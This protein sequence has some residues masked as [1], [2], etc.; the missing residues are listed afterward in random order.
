MTIWLLALFL[1]GGLGTVGGQQGAVR[2]SVKL[3]GVL[4]AVLMARPLGPTMKPLVA[5]A[6]IKSPVWSWLLPPV[7]A[8]A[9]VLIVFLIIAYFVSSKVEFYFR[10]SVPDEQRVEFFRL[11]KRLGQCLGLATGVVYLV[12]I[13][14]IVL[15]FGY[16]T[17]QVASG[18]GDSF[19]MQLLNTAH[20]D[21]RSTGLSKIAA[22]FNPA[23]PAYF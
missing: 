11:N 15:V 7:L 13:G 14:V 8:F 18:K 17:K 21:L 1:L 12:V 10:Y 23:P 4:V 3:F 19:V 16:L 6:G 5:L 2:M 9:L 20:D 22:A